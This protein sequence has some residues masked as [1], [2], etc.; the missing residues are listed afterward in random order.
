M[1]RS[2][3]L[4]L[5]IGLICAF[6]LA[7]SSSAVADSVS[8]QGAAMVITAGS[9]QP[10]VMTY[11]VPAHWG[12]G[13][14]LVANATTS[15]STRETFLIY[16]ERPEARSCGMVNT[17]QLYAKEKSF[18]CVSFAIVRWA[19]SG[20]RRCGGTFAGALRTTDNLGITKYSAKYNDTA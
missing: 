2:I 16:S 13:G 7:M 4:L 20:V 17:G 12:S 9:S 1:K 8:K 11:A 3:L 5:G 15:S 18:S 14:W 6:M 10:L 19:A